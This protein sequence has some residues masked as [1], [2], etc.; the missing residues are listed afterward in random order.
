MEVD[1]EDRMSYSM[2]IDP[3][4]VYLGVQKVINDWEDKVFQ[5]D[6]ENGMQGSGVLIDG[7]RILTAAHLS[8]KLHKSYKIRGTNGLVRNAQCTFISKKWDFA[9]LQA[10]DLPD[11]S[12]PATN[13]TRGNNFL[14]L[15]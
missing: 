11:V 1:K 4:L 8:F 12:T 9:T 14:V 6:G 3:L 13:L 2:F 10:N 7:K 15:V 5:V